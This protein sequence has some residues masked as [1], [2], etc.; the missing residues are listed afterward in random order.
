M[1][2]AKSKVISIMIWL[3]YVAAVVMI[4]VLNVWIGLG[5]YAFSFLSA[6]TILISRY[7]QQ[8]LSV[9]D[10]VIKSQIEIED[11]LSNGALVA[12]V[13]SLLPVVLVFFSR[14]TMLN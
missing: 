4:I 1:N 5:L 12:V 14:L 2:I 9:K 8:D 3:I 6:L 13:V 7:K 11:L 10:F